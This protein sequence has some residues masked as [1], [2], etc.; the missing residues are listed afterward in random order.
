[1]TEWS[2]LTH[3]S[4]SRRASPALRDLDAID[5]RESSGSV[6]LARIGRLGALLLLSL[7]PAGCQSFSSPL[8]QWRAA[9]D[10]N[11][12]KRISPEEMA[13]ASGSADSTNLLQRWISPKTTASAPGGGGSL[14]GAGPRLQRLAP[15]GQ[16]GPQPGG[17]RGVRGRPQAVQARE[18]RR[19][20]EAVRHDRQE[21]QGEHLGRERPVLPGRVPVP[22]EEI[23]RRP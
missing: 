17:R 14:L 6:I 1:M 5:R 16:A 13:D 12:F 18:V 3:T 8:A 15:D 19:G 23:R 11:L 2:G 21:P 20:R 7:L 4:G 22:A 9:Y 10:N